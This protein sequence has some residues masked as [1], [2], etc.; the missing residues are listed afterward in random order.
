MRPIRSGSNKKYVRPSYLAKAL[1]CS[2]RT[3]RKYCERGLIKK[4]IKSSGGHWLIPFPLSECGLLFR[5]TAKRFLGFDLSKEMVGDFEP[6]YAEILTLAHLRGQE[7]DEMGTEHEHTDTLPSEPAKAFAQIRKEIARRETKGDR[8][9][10]VQLLGWVKQYWLKHR[11]GEQHDCE[12]QDCPTV[13]EIAEMM[14][15]SRS[16]FYRRGLSSKDLEKAYRIAA[17]EFFSSGSGAN[18]SDSVK[19]VNRKAKKRTFG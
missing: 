15:I 4:A 7:I 9:W 14:K 13:A 12:E 3:I 19:S 11:N 10:D 1:Y 5:L 2:P 8:V 6:E 18:E 17:G 16:T